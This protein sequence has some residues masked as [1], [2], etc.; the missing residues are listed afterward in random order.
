MSNRKNARLS[1]KSFIESL[2]TSPLPNSSKAYISGSRSDV[3][4]PF[5][6]IVLSDSLVGG[7][8]EK[9][10]FS[11]NEPLYVYD[12]SGPYTDTNAHIDIFAGLATIRAKWINERQD[13]AAGAG[14]VRPTI[15]IYNAFEPVDTFAGI[16]VNHIPAFIVAQLVTVGIAHVTLTRL[17]GR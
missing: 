10:K 6:K 11:A 8:K 14:R 15:G 2:T 5:R 3:Q 9:P 1:A 12:T 7:T 17:F 16:F 4:V 13:T